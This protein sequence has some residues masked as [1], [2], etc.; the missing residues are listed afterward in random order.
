MTLTVKYVRSQLS[1]DPLTGA[2]S[3]RKSGKGR[4]STCAGF[5]TNEYMTIG[6]DGD[7]Y[8]AHRLAWFY[9]HG[10]WPARAID[11]VNGIKTDNR[12]AN[13]RLATSG[14]NALNTPLRS[15]NTSG[16]KGVHW[17]PNKQK[18]Q[19]RITVDGKKLH[20]GYFASMDD[21]SAARRA[22][23]ARHFSDYARETQP[24]VAGS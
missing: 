16:V 1:Y 24:S 8:Y 4:K 23:A 9:V 22:A 18:W 15:T 14:Q 5:M 11:H 10:E 12:L 19:A 6:I 21:A 13:L 3:W 7:Q 2:F 20:L 17:R